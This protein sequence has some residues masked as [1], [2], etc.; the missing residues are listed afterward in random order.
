[1]AREKD[2]LYID[3]T[4]YIEKLENINEKY[5]IFLRPRRFGKSLFLSTL[6]YYYDEK[7]QDEFDAIFGDTYVGKNPTPLK[8]SYRILFFEF[9]GI[10]TDG[11]MDIIYEGFK[12]NIKSSIYIYFSNYG[13]DKYIDKLDTIKTPTGLIKYFFNVAKND[14]IYLLID[15]YDQFANAI[16]AHSMQEF[17]K[18]VSKGGFVR[19][20]YE[21]IKTATLSGVVQKMFITGV[22]PITLDR[23]RSGFNIVLNIS[24]RKEFNAMAGFTHQ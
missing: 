10:N 4:Q 20:F 1:M 21:V 11:G 23:L 24:Q 13:Y 12:D 19:S 14:Q 18:I 17:L 3:K 5:M 9:S 2:Y 16:L 8:S 6:H 15:E 7:S 22:T